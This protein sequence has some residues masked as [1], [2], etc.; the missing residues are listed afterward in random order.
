LAALIVPV[1]VFQQA[2][3][4]YTGSFAEPL[5]PD[6]RD[7]PSV[8]RILKD[9]NIAPMIAQ[10]G[11]QAVRNAVRELQ[12]NARKLAPGS[13]PDWATT[14]GLY[15]T[16]LRNDLEFTTYRSVF[17]LTGTV[18][19]TNLGRSLLSTDLWRRIESLVTRPMNLEFDL[20]QG[21]RG[22]RDAIIEERLKRIT[23]CEAATVVNNNAAAL[24]LVL[25]TFALGQSVP[26]SRGEL[27]EIGGSFRLPELMA[28]S[29]C[30]LLEVGTTNRTH[31]RDY[32]AVV[33]DS[34]ML[35]KVH[36]SNYHVSGFTKEVSSAELANLG[37]Q[38]GIPSCVDVGSGTL[39]NLSHWGLPEEPTPTALLEQGIDLVTFSGD[40]LLGGVQA[41]IIVG[42][43]DLV[44]AVKNNPL[45]RALRAD[46]ITLAVLEE[47][48]K[49]YEQ[50]D[51]LQSALPLLRTLTLTQSELERRATDVQKA[52]P[53]SWRTEIRESSGQIGSGALP[54]KNI[55]SM[56]VTITAPDRTPE[57]I[58]TR[59]RGLSTPIVGRISENR[60]WLDMRGA[61]PMADLIITLQELT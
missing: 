28:R 46:K 53:K 42:R 37:Q 38:Y 12:T 8:E 45:K 34:A 43:A 4:G 26:V 21:K 60:V 16:P 57:K 3:I 58:L 48:L 15:A 59:L 24:V 20:A 29:G 44:S 9:D 18:I 17:N 61:E 14:P 7:L 27:I 25:N 32:E 33:Q 31:L 39:V 36:P 30:T 55:A 35:L 19:H 50:P 47:T 22:D 2:L 1:T 5:M 10:F 11:H 51:E 23:G 56:A 54:D 13:I 40:K 52:L 41:G 6:L 49:L